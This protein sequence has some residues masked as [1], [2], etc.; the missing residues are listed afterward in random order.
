VVISRC[1]TGRS[2]AL[3]L[4]CAAACGTSET[5]DGRSDARAD[6]T[7]DRAVVRVWAHS[8]QDVE[9]RVLQ[10]QSERF[11]Q[12]HADARVELTLIPEGSYNEQV[13][14]AA[15]A[16]DLPDV[17]E[18]DGPFVAAYAWQRHLQPLDSLLPESLLAELLPSIVEQGRYRGRH[19]ALGA[20]DSGLGLFAR[21]SALDEV[22]AR[23][24]ERP[25][26]AW[27]VD[28]L[29]RTLAALAERDRDGAP[30]DLH[31]NYRGEWYTYALQPALR[32][33]GGGL[34]DV[35]RQRAAGTLDGAASVSAL[36]RVQQWIE[37]GWVDPNVDDAAFVQGRVALSWSGHWD[38]R[39]YHARWGDD[40]IVL[41]LPDFGGGMRTGQGSW[42]WAV[43]RRA[44]DPARAAEWIRFVLSPEEISAMTD[45][46]A[47]VPA[48]TSVAE[49][50]PLYGP[51]GPLR[52]LL[53][54]LRDGWAVP[55]PRT[56]A[57]PFV[58]S[59]FQE[60]VEA[61]RNGDDVAAAVSEAVRLIDREIADNRGYPP[62]DDKR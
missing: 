17:L 48:R 52:P 8:G 39:R 58:T 11:G 36:T 50:S 54:A 41:P 31:L 27:T 14:A 57:Y 22:G 53:D 37:R 32:S 13:Q 46:N 6:G 16:G 61:A 30:L 59:A 51:A 29:E 5:A 44:R 4:L 47:A 15:L 3:A 35:E 1:S 7:D 38:F 18:L 12:S 40:V 34:I 49:A 56:P 45:A 42:V 55:R 10:E 43:T 26:D 23:V 2:I 19:W 9:R 60:V 21:R 20:Y 62:A 28:E 25:E 33:A 24:P